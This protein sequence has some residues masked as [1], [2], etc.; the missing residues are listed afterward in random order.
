MQHISGLQQKKV[1]PLHIKYGSILL[2]F[3][4]S[5]LVAACSIGSSSAASGDNTLDAGSTAT[6]R[7]GNNLSPTPSLAAYWCGAWIT[8]STVPYDPNGVVALYAKYTRNVDGNPVGIA[9]AQVQ[10]VIKWG[11]GSTLPMTAT[12]SSDGLAVFFAPIGDKAG[13]MNRLSLATF[14]FNAPGANTC[15]VDDKRPAS[16]V[17]VAP[18]AT[19]TP[20]DNNNNGDNNNNNGDN[21][22]GNGNGG[23]HRHH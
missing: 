2:L 13:A 18:A 22:N 5:V 15:I 21:G 16:F 7:L 6:I 17:I 14:T 19:P 3:A 11:D 23:H 9:G 12:T 4:I 10:A 8:K 1:L 20:T